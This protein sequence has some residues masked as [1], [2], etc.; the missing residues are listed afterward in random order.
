METGPDEF[1]SKL[2]MFCLL[3][4]ICLPDTV[5]VSNCHALDLSDTAAKAESIV[6]MY[7]SGDVAEIHCSAVTSERA[8]AVA[9][10]LAG[11][12]ASSYTITRDGQ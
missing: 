12:M 6:G 3:D 7:F 1:E 11:R 9:K 10:H 5:I 2:E 8:L 4:R